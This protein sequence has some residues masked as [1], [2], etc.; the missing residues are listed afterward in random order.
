MEV[1]A[2]GT[3]LVAPCGVTVARCPTRREAMEVSGT[4]AVTSTAPAPTMTTLMPELDTPST[5]VTEPTVPAMEAFSVAEARFDSALLSA[6][7][8]WVTAAWSVTTRAAPD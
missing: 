8:A 5:T 7:A 1:T 6:S 2:P 3:E 4:L